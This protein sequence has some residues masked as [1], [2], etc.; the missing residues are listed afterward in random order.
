M[1]ASRTRVLAK[2]V[3]GLL[4]ASRELLADVHHELAAVLGTVEMSSE[5]HVW[6]VSRYYEPE[7]GHPLWRQYAALADLIEPDA[8]VTMKQRATALEDRWRVAG[9]RRVN[10]DPG[11]LD[12]NK[13]VLASTK[14]AAHRVY[15]GKGVYAEATL[16]FVDGTFRP[17]PYTYADYAA[18]DAI[19]FFNQVRERYRLQRRDPRPDPPGG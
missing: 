8:L 3:V 18:T 16:R 7:M 19:R 11:Y 6:T 13:L 14:D 15:L 10:L 4:A 9:G 17:W 1:G 5:P 12:L 2:P